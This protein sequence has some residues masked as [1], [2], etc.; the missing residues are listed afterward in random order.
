M[1]MIPF[2]RTLEVLKNTPRRGWILKGVADPESIADHMYNMSIICLAYPWT[3]EAQRTRAVEMAIVHDMGECIVGDIAPADGISRDEK[4]LREKLAMEFLACL[5]REEDGGFAD[6][7][8]TLWEEYEADESPVSKLV[9]QVDKFEALQQAFAY[10]VRHPELDLSEFK[11]LR[12]KITDPWLTEKA[13]DVLARWDAATS[14]AKSSALPVVFVVGGPGVGKGTQCALAAANLNLEHVSVGELLRQEQMS[15]SRFSDF[16]ST[17]FRHAIPVPATLTMTLLER[18]LSSAT[19]SGKAGVLVDGFPRSQEQLDAFEEQISK[20]YST[21]A[22]ECSDEQLV[23][24]LAARS[25]SSGREDDAPDMLKKRV[26]SF[27]STSQQMLQ[28]LSKNSLYTINCD[29][30]IDEVQKA[31]GEQLQKVL[32]DSL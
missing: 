14:K 26:A 17:S 30:S 15:G 2:L 12:G 19:T 20:K 28:L 24:R 13:D 21:I 31:F 22:L 25:A 10:T 8:Q 5:M 3:N 29:G 1:A 6:R 16:I 27:R 7:I 32:N 18:V 23:S 9:H 11:G 4:H